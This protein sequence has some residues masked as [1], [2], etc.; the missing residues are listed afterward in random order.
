MQPEISQF[1]SGMKKAIEQVVIANL[2]DRFAQEQAGMIAGTLGFLQ[3]VQ[4][5]A[6]H[7][8]L[9]ENHL[10]KQLLSDA[11]AIVTRDATASK[12][13]AEGVAA[14]RAHQE[15]DPAGSAVHLKPFRFLRGSNE[16][17]RE[18]LATLIHAQDQFPAAV[19]TRFEA[20]LRPFFKDLQIR[21][22]AWVKALGFDNLTDP[23]PDLDAL[24]YR[25]GQLHLPGL[26]G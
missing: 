22:R 16:T 4:D 1:L 18:L 8:E 5:K 24:L 2:T 25:D 19:S 17:M 11:V 12:V 21:E 26:G 23:V 3:T 9:L 10:Y 20:L 13:T 15:V 14:I 6:F 7:Y